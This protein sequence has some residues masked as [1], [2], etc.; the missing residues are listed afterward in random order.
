MTVERTRIILRLPRR[1]KTWTTC[2]VG[3]IALMKALV[4][5]AFVLVLGPAAAF[6]DS[7]PQQGSRKMSGPRRNIMSSTSARSFPPRWRQSDH[8]KVAMTTQAI[9]TPDFGPSHVERIFR[10]EVAEPHRG[11]IRINVVEE[12]GGGTVFSLYFRRAPLS[13]QRI[14]R[15]EGKEPEE[16]VVENGA[17]PFIDEARRMPI[18]PD[19]CFID[20]PSHLE[21]RRDFPTDEGTF[22]QTS[23]RIPEGWRITLEKG[24]PSGALRVV[25][26]WKAGDPWWSTLKVQEIGPGGQPVDTVA[27]GYLLSDTIHEPKP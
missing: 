16:T 2:A 24:D 12:H 23:Q 15:R 25:M 11:Q 13:L 6:A 1:A 9:T 10:F 21:G 5:L 8:W 7:T 17:R 20:D 14:A 18:I 22:F 4:A 26:D 3:R 19:F 27:S